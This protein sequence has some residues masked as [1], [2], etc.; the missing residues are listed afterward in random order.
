MTKLTYSAR[1][2]LPSKEF[3]LPSERKYP[4]Y[5]KAHARNALSRV[6]QSASMKN[7]TPS[8]ISTVTNKACKVL[9]S[10]SSAV[11]ACFNRNLG[12]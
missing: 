8:Q 10:S 1:K 7:L 6:S 2:K 12:K 11:E 5:D 4:I 9:G 3:A